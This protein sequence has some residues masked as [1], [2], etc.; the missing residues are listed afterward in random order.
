MIRDR[1]IFLALSLCTAVSMWILYRACGPKDYSDFLAWLEDE[2]L[3]DNVVIFSDSRQ[4]LF[5][6]KNDQNEYWISVDSDQAEHRLTRLD[7]LNVPVQVIQSCPN[8]L[9]SRFMSSTVHSSNLPQSGDSVLALT[10]TFLTAVGW[11]R[12]LRW[13]H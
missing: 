7:Y 4:W 10:I 2:S 6:K 9:F 11:S 1:L 12:F 5:R 8:G 13:Q 3:I